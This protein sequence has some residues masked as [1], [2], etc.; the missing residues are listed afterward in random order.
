MPSIDPARMRAAI[1]RSTSRRCRIDTAPFDARP[2]IADST[3]ASFGPTT[4]V[5]IGTVTSA[6]PNPGEGV[7]RG[8]D[9]D[10]ERHDR[11]GPVRPP[12]RA[13]GS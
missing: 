2:T 3:T 4:N 8:A 12:L 6:K 13:C 7:E 11:G 9:E 10:G 5:I 1:G